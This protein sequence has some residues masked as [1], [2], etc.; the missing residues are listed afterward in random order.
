MEDKEVLQKETEYERKH[1][2]KNNKILE[3]LKKEE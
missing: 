2:G 1:K 3:E